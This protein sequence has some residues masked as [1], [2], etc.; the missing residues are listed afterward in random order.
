MRLNIGLAAW[1][2]QDGNYADFEAGQEYRF[3]LEF[4]ADHPE[5]SSRATP[6]LTLVE[7]FEYQFSGEVVASDTKLTI[8]DVGMKCYHDGPL[9]L[10]LEPGQWVEGRLT[11]GVDPFSWKETHSRRPGVP[12]LAYSWLLH[13][14][15]L[16]ETPWEESTESD[17]RRVLRRAHGS[18]TYRS[19]SQT[20]TWEDD[21]GN[22]EY[23]LDCELRAPTSE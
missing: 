9:A 5:I 12:N 3:A 18:K 10:G 17:G 11:L 6:S 8:L 13:K 4:F 21:G 16:D 7:D 1:I 20:N 19:I 14:I 2:I 23:I 15:L 22:G